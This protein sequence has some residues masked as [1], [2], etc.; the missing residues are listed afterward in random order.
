MRRKVF[1]KRRYLKM[2]F[3]VGSRPLNVQIPS[4]SCRRLI[5]MRRKIRTMVMKIRKRPARW[6][7]IGKEL[8]KLGKG[9]N[10]TFSC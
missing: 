9:R 8:G 10:S 6:R 1:W 4:L 2:K 7:K 5:K 3:R